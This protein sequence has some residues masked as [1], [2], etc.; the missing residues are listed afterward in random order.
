MNGMAPQLRTDRLFL[1]EIT[2]QDTELIVTW[3]SDPEVYKY[4]LFPH[5][6]KAE[7]HLKW[8]RDKYILDGNRLNWMAVTKAKGEHIGVFGI[9]R[10]ENNLASVE[11][12]YLL[13]P[14]YQG[15]GYAREALGQVMWYAE[16]V[17]GAKEAVAEIHAE[18]KESLKF[19]RN[20]GFEYLRKKGDFALYIRKL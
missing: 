2:E 5:L 7:E 19:A 20:L 9:K 18:N 12:S 16:K 10:Q 4:F 17:W 15:K 11:V 14:E 13:A 8:F 3:R 1:D 6:L